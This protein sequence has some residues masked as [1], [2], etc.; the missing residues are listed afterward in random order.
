M[1]K[2]LKHTLLD[3]PLTALRLSSLMSLWGMYESIGCQ[4]MMSMDDVNVATKFAGRNGTSLWKFTQRVF[5]SESVDPDMAWICW[6]EQLE[7]RRP[8]GARLLAQAL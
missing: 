2:Y 6:A 7:A 3:D 4:W 1:T 8:D 5:Q